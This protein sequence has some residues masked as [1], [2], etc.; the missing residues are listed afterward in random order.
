[1]TK[2]ELLIKAKE[3]GIKGYSKLN[4][5]ELQ[6]F[7]I[8]NELKTDVIPVYKLQEFLPKETEIISYETTEKWHEARGGFIGGS[9]IG[10]V[11]GF[12]PYKSIIDVYIDKTQGSSFKGNES[13]YWGNKLE[14]VVFDE[15]QCKHLEEFKLYKSN[16][17]FKNRHIGGNVDGIIYNL[18][19]KKYGIFEAKTTNAFNLKEWD[20][21]TVPQSYYCQVQSYLHVTGLD[22]A[23]IACLIGGNKY[24]EFYVEK[25]QEDI[26]YLV[27]KSEEFWNDNILKLIPPI[28]DGHDSYTEYLKNKIGKLSNLEVEDEEIVDKIDNYKKI[29]EKIKSLKTETEK[30]EQEL[31]L[32]IIN[33]NCD[34]LKF[35]KYKAKIINKT[36]NY[37]DKKEFAKIYPE[38]FNKFKELEK[39]FITIKETK[40]LKIS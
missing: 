26:N 39:E 3:F 15:F 5:E 13:T 9:D 25:N 17:T 29:K 30:I 1:M 32:E 35:E 22:Y 6:N 20:T 38:E 2:K 16:K 7:I 4:K 18:K 27:T 40:Y 28:P 24:K 31:M 19:T 12:N 33:Y 8:K 21:D 11:A 23:Y 36:T 34:T 10:A 14:H 37:V